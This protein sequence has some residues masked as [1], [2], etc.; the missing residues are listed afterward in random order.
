MN[1]SI[2]GAVRHYFI[3]TR[4][5][6]YMNAEIPATEPVEGTSLYKTKSGN[7]NSYTD[8]EFDL[9][10][11]EFYSLIDKCV[12][13]IGSGPEFEGQDLSMSYDEFMSLQSVDD[14]PQP[15]MHS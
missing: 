10:D 6:F 15:G 2:T 11:D 4:Y 3:I 1:R 9:S 5:E 7:G 13:V 12:K 14:A 8:V